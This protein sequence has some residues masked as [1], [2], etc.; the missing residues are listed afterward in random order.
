MPA[1]MQRP[2]PRQEE[3]QYIAFNPSRHG[4]PAPPAPPAPNFSSPRAYPPREQ[5][6]EEYPPQPPAN[7]SLQLPKNDPY[8]R[9]SVGVILDAYYN[10][11]YNDGYDQ[12]H[13]QTN[14]NQDTGYGQNNSSYGHQ[15]SYRD[16]QEQQSSFSQRAHRSQSQPELRGQVHGPNGYNDHYDGMPVEMPA[17]PVEIPA[18]APPLMTANGF[19][20][21]PSQDNVPMAL[22][23][24]SPAPEQQIK[25]PSPA[26]LSVSQSAYPPRTHSMQ[27]QT[28]TSGES[29]PRYAS[30]DP[31]PR[32]ATPQPNPNRYSDASSTRY[33]ASDV[34]PAHPPPIRP[35]LIQDQG[36]ALPNH[37]PPVRQYSPDRSSAISQQS[38]QPSPITQ[39]EYNQILQNARANPGNQKLQLLLA[40]KMVEAAAVLADEG[41]RAD[42]KTTKKNRE[43]YIFEAHKIVK[44][45]ASSV[46]DI[47]S[48]ITVGSS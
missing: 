28:S 41:G 19:P 46:G 11:D 27:S 29:L 21:P 48:Y 44:K 23:V 7:Q 20:P 16:G 45:L 39:F 33:S 36:P 30:I 47:S 5:Q 25:S 13:Y 9:E 22:R 15:D 8:N 3:G 14:G 18:D 24:G 42:P 26:Q 12:Q 1:N 10:N 4:T 31:P 43:N 32:Y 2:Q 6:H 34:L 35:G 17:E 37:P 40:K 38:T